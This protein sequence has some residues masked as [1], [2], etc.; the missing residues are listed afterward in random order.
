MFTYIYTYIL[1][2]YENMACVIT[3]KYETIHQ[4][5]TTHSYKLYQYY[6]LNTNHI[7][8]HSNFTPLIRNAYKKKYSYITVSGSDRSMRKNRSFKYTAEK[9]QLASTLVGASSVSSYR[10]RKHNTQLRDMTPPNK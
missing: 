8:E 3:M 1:Y 5:Y 9:H 7:N 10:L 4:Q 2:I 6:I